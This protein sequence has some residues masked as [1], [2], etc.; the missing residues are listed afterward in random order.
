[1]F[2]RV[3]CCIAAFVLA[4]CGGVREDVAW[5][6]QDGTEIHGRLHLPADSRGNAGRYPLVIFVN[7]S[8]RT[9]ALEVGVVRAHANELTRRGFAVL[10]YDKRGTG[11]TGGPFPASFDLM[12]DDLRAGV[13]W[14]RSDSR[15]DANRTSIIAISQGWWVTALAV[16]RGMRVRSL[17][18]IGAPSV[19]PIVQQEHVMTSEMRAR[20]A[21]TQDIEQA[22]AL[23]HQWARRSAAIYREPTTI[24]RS[25]RP[26]HTAGLRQWRSNLHCGRTM[27]PTARGIAASWISIPCR[28]SAATIS[29]S[30]SSK[31]TPMKSSPRNAALPTIAPCAPKAHQSI[32]VLCA[33]RRTI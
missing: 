6:A 29:Q 18:G 5:T 1:M 27:I 21:S 10:T 15:V 17:V 25:H 23:L 32:F 14:A 33:A 16:D 4:A 28:F 12:A 2:L 19:S 30:Q 8:G 22:N 20:G 7:G 26:R 3:F 31:A 11:G 9:P 13:E 24:R